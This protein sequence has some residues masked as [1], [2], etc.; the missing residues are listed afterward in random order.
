MSPSGDSYFRNFLVNI[1]FCFSIYWDLFVFSGTF[2]RILLIILQ[3][4]PNWKKIRSVD[5]FCGSCES[6]FG[7]SF[8]VCLFAKFC[9]DILDNTLLVYSEPLGSLIIVSSRV[10]G[11]LSKN[12]VTHF[13]S[14][15][16][17]PAHIPQ[18]ISIQLAHP[19]PTS[20]W[21]APTRTLRN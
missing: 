9:T 16:P 1:E 4:S 14:A 13:S 7:K 19:P 5:H 2:A 12:Q 18:E 10:S 8:W 17:P 11:P 21:A 15:S 3:K 6:F 20:F